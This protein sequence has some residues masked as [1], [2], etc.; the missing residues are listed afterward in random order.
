LTSEIVQSNF[1]VTEATVNTLKTDTK[2]TVPNSN[3]AA[4]VRLVFADLNPSEP[5]KIASTKT[6]VKASLGVGSQTPAGADLSESGA[7][8]SIEHILECEA[9]KADPVFMTKGNAPYKGAV[10]VPKDSDGSF[11]YWA[12]VIGG[13]NVSVKKCDYFVQFIVYR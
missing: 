2:R 6:R 3:G 11:Y 5:E 1:T 13:N 9:S 12:A 10:S 4:A 7:V 8:A